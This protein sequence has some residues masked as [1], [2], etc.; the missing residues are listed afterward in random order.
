ML[1]RKLQAQLHSLSFLRK[2]KR[3]LYENTE[4]QSKYKGKK[5]KCKVRLTNYKIMKV[6]WGWLFGCKIYQITRIM[7]M[8]EMNKWMDSLESKGSLHNKFTH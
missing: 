3:F 6:I 5:K 7:W 8:Y 4:N 1:P 2:N